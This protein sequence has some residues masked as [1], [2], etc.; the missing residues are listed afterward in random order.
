M[1][2]HLTGQQEA[3]LI[4]LAARTG[5]GTD[6]LMERAVAQMLEYDAKF[7]EAVEQGRASAGRGELIEHDDVVRQI[8]ALLQ[9]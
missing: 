1:E 3:Q 9:S 2:V 8:E 4:D 5:R 6:E 7:L